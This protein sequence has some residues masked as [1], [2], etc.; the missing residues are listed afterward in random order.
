M[1]TSTPPWGKIFFVQAAIYVVMF[2]VAAAIGVGLLS[3]AVIWLTQPNIGW[4]WSS[5]NRW[6]SYTLGGSYVGIMAGAFFTLHIWLQETSAS[7]F[8]KILTTIVVCVVVFSAMFPVV[9]F[10]KF[11]FPWKWMPSI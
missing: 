11:L 2:T 10:I 3:P 4:Q 9:K 7:K 6:I 1:I 5:F 8:S